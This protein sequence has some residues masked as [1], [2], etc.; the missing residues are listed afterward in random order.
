MALRLCRNLLY[1][2]E[3]PDCTRECGSA[4]DVQL[5]HGLAT[6]LLFSRVPSLGVRLW[7]SSQTLD[8]SVPRPAVLSLRAKRRLYHPNHARW[9]M[10]VITYCLLAGF[11]PFRSVNLKGL[12]EQ[13]LYRSVELSFPSR[14][15][16]VRAGE[17]YAGVDHGP[18]LGPLVGDVRK[19]GSTKGKGR[20]AEIHRD[21]RAQCLPAAGL[22]AVLVC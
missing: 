5:E 9:S 10:G 19:E 21:F 3:R 16:A 7:A 2:L 20:N 8:G 18:S 6:R 14:R 15:D 11:P 4:A 17:L 12:K 22:R 13:I 1:T